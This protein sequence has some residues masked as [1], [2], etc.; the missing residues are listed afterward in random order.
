MPQVSVIIPTFNRSQK[1]VRA[2]RSILNQDFRDFEIIVVDDGS[3]D[4][5]ANAL[6]NYM[7][8]IR[9][10][11]QQVNEGV[12]VARNRGIQCSVA[13]WISFL[14]SDDYWLK[15][16]LR[17]QMEFVGSNPAAVACQT[18]EIWIRKGRRVNPKKKHKKQTGDIFKQSLRLCLVSPSSVM[19]KRSLFEEVGLF[20]ETLPAGEDYDLWLRISCRYPIYLIPRELVV[21]EGGHED[22]LSRRFVSMDRYR[23]G[24]IVKLIKGGTPSFDQRRSALEELSVKCRIYGNGCIKRGRMEEGYFY[25]SLPHKLA[26]N[27]DTFMGTSMAFV[28][29][30]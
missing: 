2:V 29:D 28:F 13:P 21:K 5:T 25:L 6:T 20:D 16:K 7:P 18:E 27:G 11:R 17:V 3:T 12:S 8:S 26:D 24:A 10:I 9:Y 22:Q 23:I 19:L 15:E 1:V 14:D 4:D 30:R